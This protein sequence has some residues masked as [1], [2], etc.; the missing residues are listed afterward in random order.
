MH[1]AYDR[2]VLESRR[3]GGHAA[4]TKRELE[5]LEAASRG[6]TNAQIAAELDLTIHTVKFHLGSSYRK[7]HATNRT[8]AIARWLR[9]PAG[10][11]G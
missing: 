6:S 3:S 8:D 4:L 7:L 2:P 1:P 10:E 11:A 9:E 5:V